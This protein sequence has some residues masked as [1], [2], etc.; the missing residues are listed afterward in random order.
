TIGISLPIFN[1]NQGNVDAAKAELERAQSDV[2]RLQLSLQQSS[3]PLLQDY[4]ADQVQAERYKN[5]MIPRAERAYRLYLAKYQNMGAAYPQVLV[6][7]R[8]Y[9]QLQVGYIGVLERLW[10]NAVTLQNYLLSSG[11]SAPASSGAAST[12]LNLPGAAGGSSQ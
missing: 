5:E 3:Q 11:L 7:Q 4:L 2:V 6:S 12:T 10:M 1:R 9:F 8:T